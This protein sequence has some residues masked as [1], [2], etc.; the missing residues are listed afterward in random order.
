MKYLATIQKEFIKVARNWDDLPLEE[1]KGYLQRHPKSKRKITAKPKDIENLP[2]ADDKDK[3]EDI[4]LG[5][6]NE[7]VEKQFK[8]REA[9]ADAISSKKPRNG[10]TRYL[11][12]IDSNFKRDYSYAKSD[13]KTIHK[14]VAENMVRL[15]TDDNTT[16]MTKEEF[17]QHNKKLDEYL[18]DLDSSLSG[19]WKRYKHNY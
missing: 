9:E 8:K 12:G 11:P 6:N 1:Q 19:K 18:D 10:I 4:L 7:A 13:G 5:K 14:T 17:E 16:Y 15:S 2:Q 3:S